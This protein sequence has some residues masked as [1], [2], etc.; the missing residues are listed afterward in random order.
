[1]R[2]KG[3]K[4]K[5]KDP[6]IT[7]PMI[8]WPVILVVTGIVIFLIVAQSFIIDAYLDQVPVLAGIMTNYFIGVCSLLGVLIWLVWRK[9]IGKPIKKI[10]RAAKKVA[11]G[12]FSVQIDPANKGRR[13]NEFD[14][15][16]DD[17]NTMVRELAGNEMLKGDFISNVSHEIKTPLA[18]I[19]SYSKAMKEE[20]VTSEQR[21]QYVDTII[22]ATEKLNAMITN[23]LKL[24]KLENQQIFPMPETYPLGEQLRRC[25]L[26]FMERWE[27]KGIEF[28][29]DVADISVHYDASLLE[30]VWN[31]LLSNAIRFTDRGG[32]IILTSKTDGNHVFV[33]VRD[34]GCG[35]DEETCARVFEKFYQGDTSHAS[36]GNGLGLALAKKVVDIAG[37]KISVESAP[38]KGTAFTVALKI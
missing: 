32:R 4:N 5:D 33:T 21:A 1:M 16:I 37:G 24:S 12:D 18:V 23:I 10:A 14:V 29:I 22:D 9:Y 11:A 13:K 8:S 20:S 27:A 15:L 3:R 6:R 17:F 26:D 36:E 34:T 30:L 31:N 2:G 35:M 19:R 28:E 25:A 7:A 38:G